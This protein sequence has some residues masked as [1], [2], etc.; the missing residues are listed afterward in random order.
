MEAIELKKKIETDLSEALLRAQK[1]PNPRC[2]ARDDP[3]KWLHIAS[4]LLSGK[5]RS[6]LKREQGISKRTS[7][8]IERELS[9]SLE[10]LKRIFAEKN[11]ERYANLGEALDEATDRFMETIKDKKVEA[12][13]LKELAA[14]RSLEATAFL[15]LS[16]SATDIIEVR[17]KV[18]VEDAINLIKALPKAEVI[19]V[20]EV[21]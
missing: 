2:L 14:A 3:D 12:K 5:S 10:D 20:D 18:T 15:R 21:D 8:A 9:G 11:A 16:G 4:E 17:N 1:S 6:R 19:D 13:D 7:W